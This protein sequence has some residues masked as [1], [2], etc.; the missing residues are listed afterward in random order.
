MYQ[1]WELCD[2]IFA[3]WGENIEITLSA[4]EITL[5]AKNTLR[6]VAAEHLHSV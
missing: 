1:P 4:I 3:R 2:E 6:T 5:S